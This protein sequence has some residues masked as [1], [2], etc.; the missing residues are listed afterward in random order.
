MASLFLRVCN[1]GEEMCLRALTR[2]L[3]GYKTSNPQAR[4]EQGFFRTGTTH[5]LCSAE[6][7]SS[8]YFPLKISVVVCCMEDIGT[9]DCNFLFHLSQSLVLLAFMPCLGTVLISSAAEWHW[10]V[11]PTPRK[12]SFSAQYS[13]VISKREILK[14]FFFKYLKIHR[15]QSRNQRHSYLRSDPLCCRRDKSW[16]PWFLKEGWSVRSDGGSAACKLVFRTERLGL[17]NCLGGNS[18]WGG[19]DGRISDWWLANSMF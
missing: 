11:W 12:R 8:P 19:V 5:G 7:T 4:W 17:D 6:M 2:H 3:T 13:S 1:S 9:V 18:Q 16:G 14:M 10:S 15:A